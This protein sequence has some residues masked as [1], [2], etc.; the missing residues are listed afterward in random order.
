MSGDLQPPVQKTKPPHQSAW[1]VACAVLS[2]G[3]LVGAASE[4]AKGGVDGAVAGM[5][6]LAVFLLLLVRPSECP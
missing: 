6:T 2:L 1:G 5:G 3:I 4:V